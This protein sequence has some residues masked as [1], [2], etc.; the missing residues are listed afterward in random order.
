MATADTQQLQTPAIVRF[1]AAKPLRFT[2]QGTVFIVIIQYH[3][4]F[5]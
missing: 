4:G 1:T 3:P 5:G 2:P